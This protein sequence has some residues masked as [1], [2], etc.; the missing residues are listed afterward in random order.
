MFQKGEYVIYGSSGICRIEGIGV[1]HG[2]PMSHSGKAYYTMTPMFG[3]GTIYA[4]VDTG[5]FMRPI[6]TRGQAEQLIAQ[7]PSIQAADFAGQD[8]RAMGERYK[9]YLGTHRCEDLVRLVKTVYQKGVALQENGKK[10]TKTEREYGKQ[11]EELLHRE[12][13]IALGIPY[14]DVLGYI[15]QRVEGQA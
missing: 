11:A 14:E 13:S 8:V 6:L 7:I 15:T 3:S 2:T 4:P 9:G 12:V 1:P 10:L 5:V